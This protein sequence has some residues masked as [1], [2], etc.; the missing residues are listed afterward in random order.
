MGIKRNMGAGGDDANLPA[1][2]RSVMYLNDCVTSKTRVILLKLHISWRGNIRVRVRV[3]VRVR[4]HISWRGNIRN[5]VR[6]CTASV[7]SL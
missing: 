2:R 1:F 4:L 7:L 6:I 3:R 5:R